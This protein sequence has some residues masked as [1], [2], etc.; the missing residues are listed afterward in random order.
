M[1]DG[2]DE[3]EK[4]EITFDTES[5]IYEEVKV[6]AA[7]VQD[8]IPDDSSLAIYKMRFNST[9]SV[10][11]DTYQKN[12]KLLG[13]IQEA[14]AQIIGNAQKTS[15]ILSIVSKN[16]EKLSR[17]KQEYEEVTTVIQSLHESESKS[18]TLMKKL[19]TTVTTLSGQVARGEAFCFG[20]EDTIGSIMQDVDNLKRERDK[21]AEEINQ[22]LNKIAK[23]SELTKQNNESISNLKKQSE[24]LESGVNS[25][26]AQLDSLN[27]EIEINRDGISNLRP[28]VD[29]Q[30]ETMKSNAEKA[31]DLEGRILAKKKENYEVSHALFDQSNALKLM[32]GKIATSTK[33]HDKLVRNG[34]N[35]NNKLDKLLN[36]IGRRESDFEKEQSDLA[37]L[38]QQIEN[39]TN[40]LDNDQKIYDQLDEEKRQVRIQAKELREIHTSLM[41]E[42]VVQEGD[43]NRSVRHIHTVQHDIGVTK[44]HLNKAQLET[45]E[46]KSVARDV[47]H[48]TKVEKSCLQDDKIKLRL[49]EKEIEHKQIEIAQIDAQNQLVGDDIDNNYQKILEDNRCLDDLNE[50]IKHQNELMEG[51]RKERNTLKRRYEAL[52]KEEVGL[53]KK[54]NDVKD[55]IKELKAVKYQREIQAADEH[56]HFKNLYQDVLIKESSVKEL[57]NLLLDTNHSINSLMSEQ[58]ILK[59]ILDENESDKHIQKKEYET[60]QGAHKVVAG[61]IVERRRMIDQLKADIMCTNMHIDKGKHQYMDI[62]AEIERLQGEADKAIQRNI[63]LEYRRERLRYTEHEYRRISGHVNQ[64]KEK[65]AALIEEISLPRNVHRWQMVSATDQTYARNLQ[66]LSKIYAKLDS[67]HRKLIELTQK[68]DKLKE[69]I[70]NKI[71]DVIPNGYEYRQSYNDYVDKYKTDIEKK[72]KMIAEMNE[73]IAENRVQLSYYANNISKVRDRVNDRRSVCSTIRGR[74]LASRG[75]SRQ[76]MLYMTEPPSARPLGGGFVQKTP[77]RMEEYQTDHIDSLMI[78]APQKTQLQ[79]VNTPK[80]SKKNNSILRPKTTTGVRRR[81]QTA[82]ATVH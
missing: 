27:E 18:R 79:R 49:Y 2:K 78:T 69:Q 77:R 46:V 35:M 19:Q 45:S 56:F 11:V 47:V 59:H 39:N 57:T 48:D 30:K 24:D 13:K 33:L 74:N 58:Q 44:T 82:M 81:A 9:L 17:F 70:D 1:N 40:D 37:N 6:I 38:N 68:R 4:A 28:I 7:A 16:N 14:N 31:K 43:R 60:A 75:A 34:N 22:T 80:V 32:H 73:Q 12:Q 36:E 41:H 5:A 52:K 53:I 64:E 72:E 63:E 23:E 21:A 67:A 76:A 62:C 51:L 3:S 71:K 10:F 20:E 26:Q 50:K 8:E 65:N 66:Y 54:N 25:Y 42:E 15:T 61:V 29:K 55:T